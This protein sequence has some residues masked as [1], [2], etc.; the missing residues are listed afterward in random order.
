M[1][2]SSKK[3]KN[4]T[5]IKTMINTINRIQNLFPMCELIVGGDANTFIDPKS[6]P[7]GMNIFPN[8]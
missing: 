1:H 2:L 5:Q 6:V 7:N 4:P 8:Q 3:E